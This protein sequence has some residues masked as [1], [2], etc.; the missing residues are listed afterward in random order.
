MQLIRMIFLM[1]VIMTTSLMAVP[2]SAMADNP[3]DDNNDITKLTIEEYSSSQDRN[4]GCNVD[5]THIKPGDRLKRLKD[6]EY[7]TKHNIPISDPDDGAKFS[8]VCSTAS[9][10]SCVATECKDKKMQPDE[11]GMCFAV[12]TKKDVITKPLLTHYGRHAY[13]FMHACALGGEHNKINDAVID[14]KFY[15]YICFDKF[16]NVS[17]SANLA[18]AL[19][20]FRG[21]KDGIFVSGDDCS[22]EKGNQDYDSVKC[23]SNSEL[24]SEVVE[25]EYLFKDVNKLF[26]TPEEVAKIACRNV[27][28][29]TY[30]PDRTDIKSSIIKENPAALKTCLKDEENHTQYYS[31]GTN[32]IVNSEL[33]SLD[34]VEQRN[35]RVLPMRWPNTKI[36]YDY[37]IYRY[38]DDKYFSDISATASTQIQLLIRRYIREQL[39]NTDFNVQSIE[40]YSAREVPD[41]SRR[42]LSMKSGPYYWPVKI[43]AKVKGNVYSYD[44]AFEFREL[45]DGDK[46]YY[47]GIEKISCILN[48]G[49]FDGHRCWFLG[50]SGNT[51]KNK[52]I[53]L[54]K[55]INSLFYGG[56]TKCGATYHYTPAQ[57]ATM[58]QGEYPVYIP[59]QEETE[60]CLLTKSTKEY[61]KDQVLNWAGK[62]L[63]GVALVAASIVTAGG[64]A[65]VVLGTVAVA[66]EVTSTIVEVKMSESGT[67]FLRLSTKCVDVKCAET[68]FVSQFKYMLQVMD[69]ITDDEVKIVNSELNRLLDLMPENA[70]LFKQMKEEADSEMSDEEVVAMVADIVGIGAALFGGGIGIIK[71]LSKAGKAPSFIAK[72]T[73]KSNSFIKLKS[74][75]SAKGIAKPV[76]DVTKM[77]DKVSTLND[78][79]SQIS[80]FIRPHGAG[81]HCYGASQELISCPMKF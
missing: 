56:T 52:C 60:D 38:I 49:L 50:D 6:K 32:A 46:G 17:A 75:D 21:I 29:W 59:A 7:C 27:K 77:Y 43:N 9:V 63:S 5:G 72:L 39:A 41:A 45:L 12:A 81:S 58:T 54:N 78:I 44:V 48:N 18:V 23:K 42:F 20:A 66:A 40:F 2:F 74:L 53:N 8:V 10:L 24:S 13:N 79:Q 70:E 68:L 33:M 25:V 36:D 26:T 15:R 35:Y 67:K 28:G 61:N 30:F 34:Y 47:M 4:K 62:I 3:P 1:I 19:A 55:Y 51:F 76:K 37:D 11:Q 31:T 64:T 14:G 69:H 73:K 71:K 16:E 65:A 80:E 22:T 57:P